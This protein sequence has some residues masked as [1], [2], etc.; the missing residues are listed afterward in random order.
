[1]L[2]TVA[3][4]RVSSKEQNLSRQIDEMK[5]LGIEKNIYEIK[6]EGMIMTSYIE[7]NQFHLLHSKL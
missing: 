4:I 1:M 7:Q 5:K 3:Y 6:L 2:K